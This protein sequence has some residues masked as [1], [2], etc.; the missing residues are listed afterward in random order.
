MPLDYTIALNATVYYAE[1]YSNHPLS[2][3][4]FTIRAII[5]ALSEVSNVSV[6][7]QGDEHNNL[8]ALEGGGI[9]VTVG[10]NEQV[11]TGDNMR[12]ADISLSLAGD[13]ETHF[14]QDHYPVELQFEISLIAFP[15]NQILTKTS[16]A[17]VKICLSPGKFHEI[18]DTCT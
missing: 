7:L 1:I 11:T 5:N 14:E 8:F 16:T 15:P 6:A 4:V 9:Q 10:Q 17:I 12:A 13:L 2:T 18:C 3:P